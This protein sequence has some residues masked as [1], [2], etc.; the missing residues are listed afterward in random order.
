MTQEFY[1]LKLRPPSGCSPSPWSSIASCIPSLIAIWQR[2][3]KAQ[4]PRLVWAGQGEALIAPPARLEPTTSQLWDLALIVQYPQ[5]LREPGNTRVEI[6]G[7]FVDEFH[8]EIENTPT[9]FHTKAASGNLG[10]TDVPRSHSLPGYDRIEKM[11]QQSP[12]PGTP[13]H[14]INLL[15]FAPNTG[16]QHYKQYLEACAPALGAFGAKIAYH[17]NI[18]ANDHVQ[19]GKQWDSLLIGAYPDKLALIHGVIHP[20]YLE[21]FMMREKALADT[22]LLATIPVD[23]T[24]YDALVHAKL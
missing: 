1:L 10:S 18:L 24:S 13:V 4:Q 12:K 14:M 6:L 7:Q 20:S 21:A 8:T 3:P 16:K 23:L 9:D 2:L 19:G 15:H 5:D 11:Y 17:G 22:M